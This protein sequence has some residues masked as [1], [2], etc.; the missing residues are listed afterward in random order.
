MF[1]PSSL[2]CVTP[3][4]GLA[5]LERLVPL[6]PECIARALHKLDWYNIHL[7]ERNA[8]C[9]LR[10]VLWHETCTRVFYTLLFARTCPSLVVPASKRPGDAWKCVMCILR[11]LWLDVNQGGNGS[12]YTDFDGLPPTGVYGD[13]RQFFAW[14][15]YTQVHVPPSPVARIGI[16][17]AGRRLYTYEC[18]CTT[19]VCCIPLQDGLRLEH[20]TCNGLYTLYYH[21]ARLLAA[22]SVQIVLRGMWSS[23]YE[24]SDSESPGEEVESLESSDESSD[25]SSLVVIAS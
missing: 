17:I 25:E 5:M 6:G 1:S 23:V 9:Q 24:Y 11:G 4:S 19:A 14:H 10:E 12:P 13:T 2:A 15:A 3:A 20:D 21:P 22:T 16:N 7:V 18:Q 8:S